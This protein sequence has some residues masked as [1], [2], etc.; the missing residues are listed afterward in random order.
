MFETKVVKKIKTQNLCSITSFRKSWCLWDNAEKYC[1][2]G[3]DT[4]HGACALHAG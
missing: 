2:D 1:G 4:W 3:Q